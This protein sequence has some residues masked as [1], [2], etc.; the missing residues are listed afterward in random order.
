MQS[1]LFKFRELGWA[2]ALQ[3]SVACVAVALLARFLL[4]LI[5]PDIEVFATLFPAVLIAS[6]AAGPLAGIMAAA[7]G[8]MVG[9]W[10]FLPPQYSFGITQPSDMVDLL[11]FFV[12]S[13]AIVLVV[14]RH[15]KLVDQIR[16]ERER[17]E[18][19]GRELMHRLR[20]TSTVIQGW[21]SQTLRHDPEAAERLN[22]RIHALAEANDLIAR[23]IGQ[24]Y[25]P[26]RDVL[27]RALQP[28]RERVRANGPDVLIKADTILPLTLVF[29]ELATNAMKHGSL[30]VPQGSVEVNW[31]VEGSSAVIVWSEQGGPLVPQ[32]LRLGFGR[33]MIA[34]ALRRDQGSIEFT[35]LAAGLVCKV[36]VRQITGETLQATADLRA[37][38]R[39]SLQPERVAS[40]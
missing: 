13:V 37:A 14:A 15:R 24:A 40:F 39:P 25:A 21:V 1:A 32:M 35:P 29:H 31:A 16:R 11:V 4:A 12:A 23:S 27:E 8:A 19:V 3:A 18:L 20:N 33:Q 38:S 9:W 7:F 5:W 26:L 36:V 6:L 22:E 17:T 30:S 28:F 2:R 10:A 34:R